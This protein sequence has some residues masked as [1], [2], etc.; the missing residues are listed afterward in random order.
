M[1]TLMYENL[2]MLQYSKLR[3]KIQINLVTFRLSFPVASGQTSFGVHCNESLVSQSNLISFQLDFN[4]RHQSK[5]VRPSQK[6]K[7]SQ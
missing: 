7:D 3:I 1:K 2:H 4:Q 5:E 6:G